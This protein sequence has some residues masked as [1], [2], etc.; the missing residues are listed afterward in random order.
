MLVDTGQGSGL[1]ARVYFKL[2]YL[3]GPDCFVSVHGGGDIY[4]IIWPPGSTVR[5]DGDRV[6]VSV[7]KGTAPWDHFRRTTFW[8]GDEGRG[9]GG[10]LDRRN[11]PSLPRVPKECHSPDDRFEGYAILGPNPH[12]FRWWE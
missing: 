8:V 12:H 3:P 9:G 11:I 5:R 10:H 7:P 6:G 1:Q 2:N 4:P